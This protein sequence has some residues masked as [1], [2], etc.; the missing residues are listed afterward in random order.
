MLSRRDFLTGTAALASIPLFDAVAGGPAAGGQSKPNVLFFPIDDLRPQLGCYGHEAIESPSIDRLAAEGIRFERAYCQQAV[1]APS[2]ISLLSGCRLDTVG[3]YDLNTPLHSKHP[4]IVTMPQHFRKHGYHTV[5]L[6]KV[7]HHK[8]DDPDGWSARPWGPSGDW[9]GGWRA[10]RDPESVRISNAREAEARRKWEEAR[11]GGRNVRRPK[12]PGGPAFEGPDVADNAYPDGLVAERAVEELR[13]LKGKPFFLAAGFVKPHLPFN[14]PKQ[15]WDLYDPGD[16]RL[17]ENTDDPLDAPE[18][19]LTNWGELRAYA[20]I[21]KQGPVDDETARQLIHGYYACVSY[22]D[23]QVG[24]VMDELERLGLR[25]S[26]VI[27][28]WG[29]HGWKLGEYSAWCK[30]TNFELD[31]RGPMILSVP[32]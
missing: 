5:S 21:P 22:V 7:Y 10:Y 26:T 19:A 8:N 11:K 14:A 28:L 17:P 31:T 23:A 3:I 9:A 24:R 27:I 25:D 1:C 4:E 30:H 16:I 2:R 29:D 32:G 13:R 18:L 12:A 20:G 6:G 15:Y